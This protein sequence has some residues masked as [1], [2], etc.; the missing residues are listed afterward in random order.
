MAILSQPS[1]VLRLEARA[2]TSKQDHVYSQ[3]LLTLSIKQFIKPLIKSYKS[4]L[5]LQDRK[6]ED[7]QQVSFDP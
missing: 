7:I 4:S 1:Q 3:P 2:N 6:R 5:E